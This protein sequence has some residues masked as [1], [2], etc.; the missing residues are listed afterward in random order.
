MRGLVACARCGAKLVWDGPTGRRHFLPPRAEKGIL[1]RLLALARAGL[2]RAGVVRFLNSLDFP[3]FWRKIPGPDFKTVVL[4]L[5]PGLG[6]VRRGG[7]ITG[8]LWFSLWL[9]LCYYWFYYS[10][11]YLFFIYAAVLL[12][13]AS[14]AS[15]SRPGRFCRGKEWAHFLLPP[16]AIFYALY[17]AAVM[18]ALPFK[19]IFIHYPGNFPQTGIPRGSDLEIR[20]GGA[21]P[22]PGDLVIVEPA[23]DSGRAG[24]VRGLLAVWLAGP[25]GEVEYSGGV[26]RVDGMEVAPRWTNLFARQAW[27]GQPDREFKFRVKEGFFLAAANFN[28]SAALEL[29]ERF[30]YP[31]SRRIG[32]VEYVHTPDRERRPASD[33]TGE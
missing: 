17:S 13:L 3:G 29:S 6:N 16:A 27:P 10:P 9:A 22:Q 2:R 14:L 25:G 24:A 28:D 15:A 5:I 18:A 33:F 30:Q 21:N 4:S 1:P 7:F 31:E 19:P 32:K 20:L 26:L 8:G 23:F 12:H 11:G